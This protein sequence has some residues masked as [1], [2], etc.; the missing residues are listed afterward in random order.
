VVPNLGVCDNIY[1]TG[2]ASETSKQNL[3]IA[4]IPGLL[5]GAHLGRGLGVAFLRHIQRCRVLVHVI[6]GESPDP[7]GDFHAVNQELCMWDERLNE[8][9]QVIVVNK[10]DIPDVA[11]RLNGLIDSLRKSC[12]HT[13]VMG[14]SAAR[15]DNVKVSNC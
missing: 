2:S 6:S 7:V 12:G 8:I 10:I 1:P 14:I 5:E 13:R 3:L 11:D 15:G 9:T 4:D